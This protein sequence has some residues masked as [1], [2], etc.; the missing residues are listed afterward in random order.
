MLL[1][2]VGTPLIANK[3][4]TYS[5]RAR[6]TSYNNGTDIAGFCDCAEAHK[7][8]FSSISNSIDPLFELMAVERLGI[9]FNVVVLLLFQLLPPYH[10]RGLGYHWRDPTELVPRV[11]TL[12]LWNKLL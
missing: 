3:F 5:T 11:S 1:Q 9:F 12:Y 10:R 2:N 6:G 8:I 7:W 4:I